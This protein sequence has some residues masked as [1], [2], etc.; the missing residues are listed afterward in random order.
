MKGKRINLIPMAGAGQRFRDEGFALPKPLI[1]VDGQ[2]MVV[3][4]CD[5]LPEADHWIFVARKDIVTTSDLPAVLR[6]R[7]PGSDIIDIDYLTE[8]QASTCALA[9]DLIPDNAELLIGPCDNGMMWDRDA[10]QQLLADSSG[11]TRL[12]GLLDTTRLSERRPKCMDG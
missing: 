10:Y 8:G 4:A 6:T 7:Y 9:N 3:R 2:P 5:S 1:P 12:S 11:Q